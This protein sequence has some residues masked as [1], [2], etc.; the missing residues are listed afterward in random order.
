MSVYVPRINTLALTRGIGWRSATTAN[1]S[2]TYATAR[3]LQII[4]TWSMHAALREI[5]EPAP[6]DTSLRFAAGGI[7]D[8]STTCSLCDLAPGESALVQDSV[9]QAENSALLE[10]YGFFPGS[11]VTRV[12]NAPQGDPL[13]FRLDR[14]LVAV[15]RET[16]ANILVVR[17]VE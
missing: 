2:V 3:Y 16:A 10:S 7:S 12:G 14:R 9:W 6:D 11:Q 8:A 15:R 1:R 4:H 17:E 13:I 5:L